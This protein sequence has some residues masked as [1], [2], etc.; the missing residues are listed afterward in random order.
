M[1]PIPGRHAIP[2]GRLAMLATVAC[3]AIYV[4]TTV[5]RELVE[6][7]DFDLR[8]TLELV[9]YLIVVTFLA[10]SALMY[11]MARQGALYRFRDHRRVPR[12]VLDRHFDGGYDK[13]ITVLVPSY[14]EDPAVVRQTLWS[15]ALQEFPNL[16]IVLLIDDPP[17]PRDPALAASLAA[18]R[19]LPGEIE[20]AL[21]EPRERF[22]AAAEAG[23]ARSE[24]GS[25]VSA[26]EV[27]SLA[28]DY[29]WAA[30]WLEGMAATETTAD[31]TDDFFV[32]RV[33]GG[34]ASDLRLTELALRAAVDQGDAPEADRMRQ[35]RNRLV[36]IFSAEL[37][38]F[39]RKAYRSLSHEANKAM[40]INAYI[41]L[42]GKD[43]AAE[44]TADGVVLREA[45]PGDEVHLSVP[46]SEYLLTLDADSMLLRDYCVRLVEYLEQ[47]GHERVAVTQTPYSSYRGAPTRIERIAGATTDIQHIQHQGMSFYGAT[48]WVGANAIIR[49][50]ALQDIATTEEVGGFP[51]TTYIQDRTVIEDTESSIDIGAHEWTLLNY[52]ER[53]SYSATPPDFGSLIVQRRRWA[54]GGLLILPKLLHQLRERRRL[55]ERVLLREVLLRT[56]YMA[57]IAWASFG[58]LFLLAYP[59]DSRLLSVWVFLA[60]VPYFWCMGSDLKA[61]GHRFT[62]IFRIYGFNLVLLAVNLAG[63]LKSLQQA[64][65]GEKIPFAR[66]PKVRNRTAAPA[67][68]VLVP[69]LI[70][71]FS[72]F[73]FWRDVQAQNWGNAA[74]ALFNAL[75]CLWAVIAYIGVWNSIV[76]FVLG[77][78]DWLFVPA[79][80][81]R[82]AKRTAPAYAPGPT[83]WQA[84]LYHGDRRLGPNRRA[85][86]L[87]RRRRA[88]RR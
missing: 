79:D 7:N 43:W 22:A 85:E 56:N 31:H 80:K 86:R 40:N 50:R 3:W 6:N 59:Y 49:T 21:R 68:Y 25:A 70:V 46:E 47:P 75:L 78:V 4:I 32:E 48:F 23:N 13:R 12:A 9:S 17:H 29:R 10:F 26:D 5:L 52:P 14:I 73:T 65:T 72:A 77:V 24:R 28:D 15:A 63:V 67:L 36:W 87:E 53:L 2:L 41:S 82:R 76:D 16:R 37:R 51:I 39:E 84:I 54:N 88:G 11:L 69:W 19:A 27:S 62:D 42:I 71:G 1:H 66:T 55:R 44:E 58:L 18:S 30:E 57:S 60:A 33:L 38:S 74:F 45:R 35:L 61:S 83:D 64:V 8:L 34:L 81:P 20:A